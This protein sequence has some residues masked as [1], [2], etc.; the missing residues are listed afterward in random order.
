MTAVAVH[1]RQADLAAMSNVDAEFAHRPTL[2][3]E[4][5]T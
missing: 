1:E 3:L 4:F 2:L 5:S